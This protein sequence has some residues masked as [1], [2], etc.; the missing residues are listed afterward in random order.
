MKLKMLKNISAS[1]LAISLLLAGCSNLTSTPGDTAPPV[2][3]GGETPPGVPASGVETSQARPPTPA[4]APPL[5]TPTGEQLSGPSQ[6]TPLPESLPFII[7]Q[8]GEPVVGGPQPLFIA[9]QDD[10][11]AAELPTG[12][13]E[14]AFEAL[15]TALSE[16]TGKL[17][18]ILYAG[19]MPSGG[20]SVHIQSIT[21]QEENEAEVLLVRYFIQTPNPLFGATTVITYPYLIASLLSDIAPQ[22]VRFE[23]VEP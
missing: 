10:Q 12:L 21:L 15:E 1:C 14:Q 18:L 13:P 7:I 6:P 22:Q 9:L 3:S 23:R 8:A 20:F 16:C 2:S 4:S 19:E 11:S 5:P 17:L